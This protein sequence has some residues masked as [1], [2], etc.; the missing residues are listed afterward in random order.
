MSDF[1]ILAASCP[2]RAAPENGRIEYNRESLENGKYPDGT[3]A[4]TYC[5][6]GYFIT[7]RFNAYCNGGRWSQPA[8]RCEGDVFFIELKFS[9]T[10]N[11][12]LQSTNIC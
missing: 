1:C 3:G 6:A 8:V 5:N 12:L 4:F 10:Q 9:E 11:F 2:F 7:G